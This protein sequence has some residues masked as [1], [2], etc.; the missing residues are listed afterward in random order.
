[1]NFYRY[2]KFG[3]ILYFTDS[4]SNL[5]LAFLIYASKSNHMIRNNILLVYGDV[6]FSN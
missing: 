6:E 1:M 4:I 5:S 2:V 3:F